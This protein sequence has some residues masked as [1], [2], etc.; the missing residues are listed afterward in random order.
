[1]NDILEEINLEVLKAQFNLP[2]GY[3][4]QNMPNDFIA[5]ATA[6]LGRAAQGVFRNEK[7]GC[8]YR[9]NMIKAAG[10]LVSA[11]VSYDKR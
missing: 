7:E 8:D 1:M 9:Q 2:P 3:E 10:I 6:Y 5:Y 11:I 4:E